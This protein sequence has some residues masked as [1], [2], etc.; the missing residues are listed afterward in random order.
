MAP[1]DSEQRAEVLELIKSGLIESNALVET[2]L[3]GIRASAQ[4]G[5]D[6]LK[7]TTEF[8][9]KTQRA[10]NLETET[11]MAEMQKIIAAQDEKLGNMEK[12]IEAQFLELRAELGTEFDQSKKD[13]TETRA[14]ITGFQEQQGAMIADIEK[15]FDEFREKSSEMREL[16]GTSEGVLQTSLGQMN[17]L[18]DGSVRA[19]NIRL[20]AYDI[21]IAQIGSKHTHYDSFIG[22][23]QQQQGKGGSK[24]FFPVQTPFTGGKGFIHDKDIKM[25]EFPQK[26][27]SAEHFRRWWK[28]V[29]EYCEDKDGFRFASCLVCSTHLVGIRT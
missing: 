12:T 8:E 28:D 26:P 11:K 15:S 24:G 3:T 7:S 21:A 4:K 10:L 18:M 17:T 16:I 22:R 25:P 5:H 29:A 1:L 20:E 2:A 13:A 9:I 6:D 27:E 23:Q 19:M 14:V